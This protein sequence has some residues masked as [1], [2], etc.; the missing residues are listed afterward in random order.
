M[1]YE[2][3]FI[4][5]LCIVLLSGCA[6]CLCECCSDIICNNGEIIIDYTGDDKNVIVELVTL[7]GVLIK[8]LKITKGENNINLKNIS[9]H[10]VITN[11]YTLNGEL[12]STDKI[13]IN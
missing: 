5:L 1:P 3:V 7:N 4:L 10:M 9:D 12:I 8:T 6:I 2:V 13:L 11:T